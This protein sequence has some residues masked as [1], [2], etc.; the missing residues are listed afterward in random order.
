MTQPVKLTVSRR[1]RGTPYTPRIEELGVSAYSIVNRTI[2]PKG[3]RKTVDEDYWHMREH[4]QL[5]DVSCQRQIELRG[6][7]AAK[8]M[9]LMTPRDLRKAKIGRCLYAPLVDAN[10]GMLNDPIIQKLAD[11]HFWL[12]IADSDV[13]LWAK[14]LAQGYGFDVSIKEADVWPLAVQGPKSDDLMAKV[15]GDAVRKIR[16]FRFKWLDFQGHPLL[17][18]RTGYSKQGGFEIYLDKWSLGLPLWDALWE[19]GEEFNVS[20]G[21]PNLIERV[22][23]GLL[24]LGNEMT[25]ANNPL[26]CG[27]EQYCQLD[28]S[29]DY[30]GR[31]A[32]MQI[33]A[34]GVKRQIR[35]VL[36]GDDRCPP[37]REPWPL[38]VDGEVVGSVTTAIW[39]PRFKQNVSL[40]MVDRGYWTAGQKVTVAC[41]DGKMR[42]GVVVAL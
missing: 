21:S 10:G 12:S 1:Q 31:D 28:G 11:D 17:V 41:S 3:F 13:A 23:G 40:G 34:E 18:A 42:E 19:A 5:W 37:C 9:Q 4:V 8:L 29:I 33:H 36:F 30:I 25:N 2:L 38:H 26:E 15:F 6:P 32:L 14:G 27:M 7:D 16:F 39:S 22:E 24:S 20:P 35:G